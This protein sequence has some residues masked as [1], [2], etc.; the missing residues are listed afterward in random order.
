LTR[1]GE[2][3]EKSAIAGE[4]WQGWFL[5][6]LTLAEGFILPGSVQNFQAIAVSIPF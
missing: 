6:G 4:T 3:G 5:F 2:D 1:L